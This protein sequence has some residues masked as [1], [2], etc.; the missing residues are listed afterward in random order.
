MLP[1]VALYGGLVLMAGGGLASIRRRTRR[2]GGIAFASG[3]A[4]V[5][6]ALVWPARQSHVDTKRTHLDDIMPVWQFNEVHGIDI[7]APPERV[8]AAIRAV[9]AGEITM[10]RT[11]TTIR[12]LGRDSGEGILNAPP[13]QPILD[14]ATRGGFKVLVDDAPREIVIGTRVARGTV[15]AMNFRVDVVNGRSRLTTET[16]VF[17][18]TPRAA[19]A[20]APYWRLILPGSDILRRTWLRAIAKRAA[21]SS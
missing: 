13:D 17:S 5:A 14:V 3:A 20:F 12:R 1:S 2:R 18:R 4:M 6:A 21:I 15:A 7:D 10:F 16:R 9:T 11:F 8:F 19:R